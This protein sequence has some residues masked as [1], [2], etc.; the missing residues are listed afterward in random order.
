M[1]AVTCAGSSSGSGVSDG[2]ISVSVVGAG[3]VIS[4]VT[5]VGRTGVSVG[6][7]F[8]D[9]GEGSGAD[10]RLRSGILQAPRSKAAIVSKRNILLL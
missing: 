9:V 2:E 3:D 6:F 8:T 10:N 4:A 5:L 1:A 7:T